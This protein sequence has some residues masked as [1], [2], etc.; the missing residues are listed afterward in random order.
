MTPCIL[1]PFHCHSGAEKGSVQRQMSWSWH[2]VPQHP[3]DVGPGTS[4]SLLTINRVP[5][6]TGT[7]KR[8]TAAHLWLLGKADVYLCSVRYRARMYSQSSLSIGEHWSQVTAAP[9]MAMTWTCMRLSCEL[10]YRMPK[11]C[12]CLP[13]LSFP[14]KYKAK[15]I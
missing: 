5:S 9:T 11:H 6:K 3:G 15:F 8:W 14:P 7:Q 1:P 13:F 12:T 2:R 10:L 4:Q